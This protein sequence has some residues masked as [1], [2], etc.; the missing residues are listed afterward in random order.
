MMYDG[1]DDNDIDDSPDAVDAPP[2]ILC[3]VNVYLFSFRG[4]LSLLLHL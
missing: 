2:P 3:D 4:I 1:H